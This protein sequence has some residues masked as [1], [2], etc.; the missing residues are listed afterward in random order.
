MTP[1][2]QTPTAITHPVRRLALIRSDGGRFQV[3]PLRPKRTSP[4]PA[5]AR[6][7]ELVLRNAS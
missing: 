5:Q 2:T 3:E 6:H 4:R 7:L 1:Q